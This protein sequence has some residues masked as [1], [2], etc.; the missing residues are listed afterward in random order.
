MAPW[1]LSIEDPVTFGLT[2]AGDMTPA[3][4]VLGFARVHVDAHVALTPIPVGEVELHR[5]HRL[6]LFVS[7]SGADVD[8]TLALAVEVALHYLRGVV[9]G[10]DHES[11]TQSV[12]RVLPLSAI[13]A[14]DMRLSDAS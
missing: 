10:A 5:L 4:E 12:M 7:A 1:Y 14:L 2:S 3:V 11:V 8:E 13:A 9:G 6:Q